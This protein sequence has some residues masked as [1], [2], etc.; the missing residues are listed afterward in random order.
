MCIKDPQLSL[1]LSFFLCE[2]LIILHL[3]EIFEKWQSECRGITVECYFSLLNKCMG[4]I[5]L[6]Y[7][8]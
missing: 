6:V 2:L 1:L 4:D 5:I 3:Y 7:S 8:H